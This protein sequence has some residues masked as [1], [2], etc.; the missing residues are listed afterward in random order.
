MNKKVILSLCTALSI[1]LFSNGSIVQAEEDNGLDAEKIYEIHKEYVLS[2]FGEETDFA[3]ESYGESGTDSRSARYLFQPP[4][5]K[6]KSDLFDWSEYKAYTWNGNA[7]SYNTYRAYTYIGCGCSGTVK[8]TNNPWYTHTYYYV[9][10]GHVEDSHY[11]DYCCRLCSY[12]DHYEWFTCSGLTTG[13][14]VTP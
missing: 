7:H 10:K 9:D 3:I 8:V 5:C 2:E 12:V 13:K 4:E 1:F 11:Y 6:H 14:H